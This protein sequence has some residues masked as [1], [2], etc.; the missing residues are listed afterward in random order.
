VLGGEPVVQPP[1]ATISRGLEVH[2]P[3]PDPPTPH[4]VDLDVWID[5]SLVRY[6]YAWNVPAGGEQRVGAGSYEP[7]HHVKA[8]TI[9]TARRLG[10]PPE[11]YQG[12]WFPHRLRPAVHDGVMFAGDSAGHCL[13]LTG[14]GIRTALHF[15]GTAG[16][17][18]RAALAG[19]QTAKQA[20]ERYSAFS[21]RHKPLFELAYALQWLMPRLPP[22]VLDGVLDVLS[23][24]RLCRPAAAWYL[25][26]AAP[27]GRGAPGYRGAQ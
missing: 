7:R 13:P 26:F 22:R 8:P 1:D 5:R 12:N 25:R 10:L 11:G 24:P 9:E 2:P 23:R 18:V 17:E 15:G 14:E 16:A 6:G 27:G 3:V 21:R 19:E 20:Q 4:T